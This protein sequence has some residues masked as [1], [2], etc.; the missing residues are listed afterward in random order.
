MS[1]V[2]SGSLL[3]ALAAR[4]AARQAL[5]GTLHD[6]VKGLKAVDRLPGAQILHLAI[7][8]PLRHRDALTNLLSQ[9][10]DRNSPS[11][12]QYLNAEEF[13]ASF[14]PADTDYQ[15]LI[16]FAKAS[17]FSI[18]GTHS[19]RMVLDV[20]GSVANIEKCF[21]VN[22]LVY[23]HPTEP[24]NF[25]APDTEPA[26]DLDVPVL[27]IAGLDNYVI[28][29]PMSIH[30]GPEP[31]PPGAKPNNGSGPLGDYIGLDFR[32][33]YVPGVSL[34]G[35]GQSV[36]LVEFDSYYPGDI[37]NYFNLAG[38]GLTNE[39]VTL[40]NIVLD[41]LSGPPGPANDEVA[42]DIEMAISMAPGLSTVYVYETPDSTSYAD[43]IF[44]HIAT[45]NLAKQIS[46]SWSGFDDPTIEQDLQEFIA[47]GQSFFIASGD[48][49][50]YAPV[51]NTVVQ[52][53]DNPYATAV[54]GT[55]LST[56]G[57]Q[58]A[59]VSETTW[60]WFT[61]IGSPHGSGGG[62]SPN[63]AIPVWQ[64]GMDMSANQGSTNFRNL[65][66][67]AMVAD[68]LYIEDDNGGG[69][70]VGGTSAAAPLW[71]GLMALVNQQN[72]LLGQPPTGFLNPAL[73][74]IGRGPN[75]L[76]C[77]HDITT[78]NNTNFNILGK[79][80]AT[81]GYD[82]CTGWGTPNGSN[83]ITALVQSAALNLAVRNGGFETGDFT[84]WTLEQ[85]SG[86]NTLVVSAPEF[87]TFLPASLQNATPAY[88]HS[89]SY[90]AIMGQPTSLARVS[91]NL[92]TFPGQPYLI[93][94]WLANPGLVSG[95]AVTPNEFRF[96]WNGATLFDQVNMGAFAW[97]N[98]QYVVSAAGTNSVIAFA[99]QNDNDFFSLDDV[100]AQAIPA[101]ALKLAVQT[102]GTVT[103][104]WTAL[105]GMVYQLQYATNLP[106]GNWFNLGAPTNAAMGTVSAS[107]I[108][109][110]DPHRF[111]RL[112]LLP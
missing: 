86:S 112:I 103:L 36:A 96:S 63:F 32:D 49:G 79:Y 75:Y 56:S 94:F 28:P 39:S 41:G 62:I 82:L 7:G 74:D 42:L 60:N 106:A 48:F 1:L 99:A 76:N 97:T 2:L 101:P 14:G 44:N 24:R 12:H 34:T 67:V 20:T 46:S 18:T 81:N 25:Y 88:I 87:A 92:P 80:F 6:A 77:F 72:A 43:D 3:F 98:L 64:Q 91:Q 19:N 16:Q 22:L 26:V 111:Y 89:G 54:G 30:S 108:L 52:P 50:A 104:A 4:P 107:D 93:S 109:P 33:A 47:Q 57:P 9:L 66:D 110:P 15:A 13:A 53:V 8:L 83:L 78:G 65:P 10:Y 51:K 68:A 105:A 45:D 23:P 59:W 40:S 55:T 90:S 85:D 61:T 95:G 29:H 70:S 31:R 35:A 38:S 37:T 21:H 11:Y 84:G 69:Q 17:G 27:H 102:N 73:Y 5:K 58:G 100:G 71:A